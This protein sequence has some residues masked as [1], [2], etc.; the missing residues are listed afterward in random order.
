MNFSSGV[1]VAEL[2]GAIDT[3]KKLGVAQ[4]ALLRRAAATPLRQ[5][6]T[7]TV[8]TSL[9]SLSPLTENDVAH[10]DCSSQLVE[11]R[12]VCKLS[13]IRAPL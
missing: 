4:F 10:M 6:R 9:A 8:C 12:A 11:C 13:S 1:V 2:V 5:V 3:V 7:E